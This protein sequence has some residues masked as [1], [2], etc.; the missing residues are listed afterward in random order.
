MDCLEKVD[1]G[2]GAVHIGDVPSTAAHAHA[3]LAQLKNTDKC[4]RG[5]ARGTNVAKDCLQM[6]SI[7][8][9]E[10]EL[11]QK[12]MLLCMVNP[13]SPLQWDRPMIEGMMEYARLGQIVVPSP[14]IMAGATGPVTLAG[15]MTQHNAEVL[16]AIALMQLV[17]PGTPVLYGTVSTVLDMRTGMTRLGAPELGITHVGF[18]QLAKWY[19]IPC[20]GAAGSTDSKALDIQA[21]YET[22]FNLLLAACAGFNYITYALGGMDSSNSVCYEKVVTDHDLLGMIERMATGVEV[23]DETIAMDI[24]DTTGPGG[25]FLAS[26]HTRDYHRKEHFIPKLFDTD[27]Y[28]SW[29]KAGSR[30]IRERAT[31]EVNRIL[32]E[33]QPPTLEKDVCERLENYVKDVERRET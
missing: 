6:M 11:M 22:A 9:S 17:S 23:G 33:H 28:D 15:M 16:S 31:E 25:H 5:R 12:P 7:I 30:E 26:H 32:R 21:G 13:T 29:V 14:E 27:S 19:D 10:D 2:Y 1:D 3:V 20:R 8:S 4:I 18:A 24:M